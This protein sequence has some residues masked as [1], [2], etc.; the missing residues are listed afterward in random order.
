[1][2]RL[3]FLIPFLLLVLLAGCSAGRQVRSVNILPCR[4]F[5]CGDTLE[6]GNMT[7]AWEI[8]LLP[9]DDCLLTGTAMPRGVRPETKVDLA[10][11]SVELIR[12]DTVADSFSFPMEGRDL[13]QPLRFS[14]R[15]TP[16]GGFDGVTFNWDIHYIN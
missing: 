7:L 8:Q 13:Q 12:D 3:T 5:P 2:S 4:S 16:A 6:T 1:M 10:V 9:S 14:H 11:L 15:F